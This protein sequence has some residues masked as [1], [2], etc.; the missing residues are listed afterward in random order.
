MWLIPRDYTV[1]TKQD[2]EDEEDME[3]W[4]RTMENQRKRPRA[5]VYASGADLRYGVRI[6]AGY[7][8][9]LVFFS[10]PPD[11]FHRLAAGTGTGEA[12]DDTARRESGVSPEES[13]TIHGSYVDTVH[14][15]V[16]LAVDSGPDMTLYAFSTDG[17]VYVYQLGDTLGDQNP[18]AIK[19]EFGLDANTLPQT[20]G[21]CGGSMWDRG[22]GEWN[23]DDLGCYVHRLPMDGC[24][25]EAE[26]GRS[27]DGQTPHGDALGG[28]VCEVV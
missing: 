3:T 2:D 21:A 15:L 28:M 25:S 14:G 8:D 6:A 20:A 26:E 17:I 9:R 1:E 27:G 10:V 18:V 23:E 4:L 24:L 16:D 13:I 5:S 19:K 11:V 12:A 7:N 22:A